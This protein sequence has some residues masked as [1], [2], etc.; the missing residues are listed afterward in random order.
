MTEQPGPIVLLGS[1]ETAPGAQ[2]I[3]HR[4]FSQIDDEVRV[5]ILETPAGYEPNS[6]FVA[7]QV[8]RYL[9]QRLQNFRPSIQ[10]VPARKRGTAFSPDDATIAS[11]LYDANVLFMGPGSPTYTV[12]QLQDSVVWHTLRACHRLGAAVILASAATLAIS[13][14]TLPVYEIYKVGEDLHWKAGL[15]FFGDFG[16]STIF[17][18]HWNNK[19]GGELL[20]TSRCYMGQPRFEAL[21]A[22]TPH[23]RD[24]YTVVGIDEKTALVI[25]PATGVCTVMGIGAVTI[26]RHGETAVYGAG[27]RFPATVLGPFCPPAPGEGIPDTIWQATATGRAAAAQKRLSQPTPDPAVL[28]LLDQRQAARAGK[29][30]AGADHLRAQIAARGWRVLDTPTGPALEPAN[31]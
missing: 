1:G 13:R 2:K 16:L 11:A 9:E 21:L 6:D 12:R 31:A 4:L 27:Q 17:V 29:D 20:D 7:K 15:D 8:G 14:L 3:Y 10:I 26:I 25:E 18:S 24:D 22:I 30:W 23:G 19:D 28:A 5:A